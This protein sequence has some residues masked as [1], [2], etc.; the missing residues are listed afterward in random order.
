MSRLANTYNHKAFTLRYMSGELASVLCKEFGVPSTTALRMLRRQGIPIHS[1]SYV[2]RRSSGHSVDESVFDKITP[3]SAYW[4]GFLMADGCI[5]E[6]NNSIALYLSSKDSAHLVKFKS[7]LM[8]TQKISHDSARPSRGTFHS[9]PISRFTIKS[10]RLVIAL[11]S[12][13]VTPKKSFTAMV[14]SNLSFD[15][16]FWR[17]VIDGNGTIGVYN[18]KPLLKLT[19]SK[20]LTLQFTMLVKRITGVQ[21]KIGPDRTVY[22][23]VTGCKTAEAMIRFLYKDAETYLCRKMDIATSIL[24]S[25][26]IRK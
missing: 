1:R 13:G 4:I 9:N 8:A 20:P 15:R 18:K 11:N 12:Y 19:G 23:A 24:H 3:E 5:T 14:S 16:N 22:R 2:R 21:I 7:F 17:G 6:K 25:N 26:E 10:R